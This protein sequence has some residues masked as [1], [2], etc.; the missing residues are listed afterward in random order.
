MINEPMDKKPKKQITPEKLKQLG[1]E[2]IGK[3]KQ[4]SC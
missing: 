2:I 4:V 1:K 3:L